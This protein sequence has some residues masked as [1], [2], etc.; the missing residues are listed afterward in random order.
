MLC[1]KVKSL[2]EGVELTESLLVDG[3]V[4]KWIE[5]ASSFF[6]KS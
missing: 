3:K 6:P 1:G 5:K 2:G 4:K